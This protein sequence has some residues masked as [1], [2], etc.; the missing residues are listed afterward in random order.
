MFQFIV[1]CPATGNPSDGFISQRYNNFLCSP[2]LLSKKLHCRC[3]ICGLNSCFCGKW[4]EWGGV[5]FVTLIIIRARRRLHSS[6]SSQCLCRSNFV[7]YVGA[8]A[9][10][11]RRRLHSSDSSQCFTAHKPSLA[12]TPSERARSYFR[13]GFHTKSLRCSRTRG[14]ININK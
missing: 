11:A 12:L 1:V 7:R 14:S 2:K 3:N 13:R 5:S 10:R 9:L 4:Q 8:S 6:D